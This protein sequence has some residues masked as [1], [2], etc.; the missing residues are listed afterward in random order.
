[1]FKAKY[2]VERRLIFVLFIF[3]ISLQL[4]SEEIDADKDHFYFVQISDTHIG[5]GTNLEITQRLVEQINGLPMEIQFVI[6]TGDITQDGL[7]DTI[8]VLSAIKAL[9]KLDAPIYYVPGNHDIFQEKLEE[10][11]IIFQEQFGELIFTLE[12]EDVVFIGIYSDPLAYSFSVENYDPFFELENAIRKIQNKPIVVFHHIPSVGFFYN[13]EMH[14]G[15]EI[16]N[17]DRWEEL[18]NSNDVIAIIAG[19]FHGGEQHWI[20][21][22]PLYVSGSVTNRFGRQPSFRVYEYKN[23]KLSYR[24]QYENK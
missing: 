19:H 11:L 7:S 18:L 13:N 3:V 16:E 24:T 20:G 22:I 15:W 9:N 5:K 21:N 4:L 23:G 1:M 6:H 2:R 8:S 12:F 14:D 17:R 10:E